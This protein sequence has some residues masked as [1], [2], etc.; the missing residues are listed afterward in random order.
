MSDEVS[1]CYGN[2]NTLY[3]YENNDAGLLTYIFIYLF[4]LLEPYLHF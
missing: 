2:K 1:R 3:H 4:K